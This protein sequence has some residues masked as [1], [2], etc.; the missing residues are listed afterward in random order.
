MTTVIIGGG[1]GGGAVAGQLRQFGHQDP[2]IVVGEEPHPPYQRPPLS[3]G[4]LKGEVDGD[5]LLL[6]PRDWYAENDI[7]LRTSTRVIKID[8]DKRQLTLSTDDTLDYD[9]LILATGARARQLTL[10]GSF[11]WRARAPVARIRVS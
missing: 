3:K 10:P 8:R 2:I 4:W 6:R 1:H 7:D 9:I 5:G 11:S